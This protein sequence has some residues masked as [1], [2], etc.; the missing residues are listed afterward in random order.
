MLDIF[1]FPSIFSTF[2]CAPGG[3]LNGFHRRNALFSGFLL[4]CTEQ[5]HR[6]IR[7]SSGLFIPPASSLQGSTGRTIGPRDP[8]SQI[9]QGSPPHAASLPFS[10]DHSPSFTPLD[11]GWQSC[12]LFPATGYC[13]LPHGFLK[14]CSRLCK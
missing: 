11:L 13:T 8:R 6:R 10:C 5:R 3:Y 12:L 2:L 4:G 7:V 1:H 14:P 9:P